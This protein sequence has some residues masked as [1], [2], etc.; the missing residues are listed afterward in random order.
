M[1]KKAA[2]FIRGHFS[3]KNIKRKLLESAAKNNTNQVQQSLQK[4]CGKLYI[5]HSKTYKNCKVLLV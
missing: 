2:Y 5:M 1:L 4:K 3:D